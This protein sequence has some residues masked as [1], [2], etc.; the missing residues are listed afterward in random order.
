MHLLLECAIESNT[1][2]E[3]GAPRHSIPSPLRDSASRSGDNRANPPSPLRIQGAGADRK[4][5]DPANGGA[6]PERVGGAPLTQGARSWH[7]PLGHLSAS[8]VSPTEDAFS[9]LKQAHRVHNG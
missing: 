7:E 3:N 8:R 9:A 4:G 6:A 5:H 1:C 2:V